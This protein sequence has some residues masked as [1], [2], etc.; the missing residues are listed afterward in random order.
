VA[1]EREAGSVEIWYRTNGGE[2]ELILPAVC[3]AEAVKVFE[4]YR[5]DW[6]RLAEGLAQ[7]ANEMRRSTGF[8]ASTQAINQA[9]LSLAQMADQL[10]ASFWPLVETMAKRTTH[11]AMDGD[12]IRLAGDLSQFLKLSAADATVL[13]SVVHAKDRG[14]CSAF[15]SRDAKAFDTPAARE[16]M[17]TEG[18]DFYRHPSLFIHAALA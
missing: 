11:I 1:L 13:S 14:L 18:I 4:N 15:M 7:R 2:I 10:E 9:R 17:E 5:R 3:L 8:A 6:R 12:I 16:Y